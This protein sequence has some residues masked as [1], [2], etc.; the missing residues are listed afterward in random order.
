[1]VLGTA[2]VLIVGMPILISRMMGRARRKRQDGAY[3]MGF[4]GAFDMLDPAR[5]RARETIRIQMEIGQTDEGEAG[6]LF[7]P[8]ADSSAST[9]KRPSAP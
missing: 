9:H 1:M 6:E 4:D 5:A 7:E 3:G 8:K 2:L